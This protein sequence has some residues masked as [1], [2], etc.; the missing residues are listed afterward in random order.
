MATEETE[1]YLF[2]KKRS[3]EIKDKQ[4]RKRLK[5]SSLAVCWMLL[6]VW[7]FGL[8]VAV[9]RRCQRGMM[10]GWKAQTAPLGGCGDTTD[11]PCRKLITETISKSYYCG[12]NWG[13]EK[14]NSPFPFLNVKDEKNKKEPTV[15]YWRKN[16][17]RETLLT[18]A[19]KQNVHH[20]Y[21]TIMHAQRHIRTHT[22]LWEFLKE[23]A[24]WRFA[25][26][27]AILIWHH[28]SK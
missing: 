24:L 28:V 25:G 12:C 1:T 26:S 19:Y 15:A 9:R 5:S 17:C 18:I 20:R 6:R 2:N 27:K 4:I 7:L 11:S 22:L 13:T 16:I 3:G 14:I 23:D 10:E 8:R 21:T